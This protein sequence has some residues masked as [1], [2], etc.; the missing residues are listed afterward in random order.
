M[1]LG[2]SDLSQEDL[3]SRLKLANADLAYDVT[4][5]KVKVIH[6]KHEHEWTYSA[7][8]DGYSIAATCKGQY[9]ASHC[10]Y[11]RDGETISLMSSKR[12]DLSFTYN[13]KQRDAVLATTKPSQKDNAVAQGKV[14]IVC[15]RF[16]RCADENDT[17]GIEMEGSQPCDAGTYRVVATVAIE[18][19]SDVTLERVFKINP[20][21]LAEKD[22]NRKDLCK[23]EVIG[24]DKLKDS[25][26]FSNGD[27]LND[28]PSYKWT[29]EEITPRIKVTYKLGDEW[30]E[31]KEGVDFERLA[32]GESVSEKDPGAYRSQLWGLGN[33][34]SYESIYSCKFFYWSIYGTQFE[35][36]Q[37][38]ALTAPMMARLTRRR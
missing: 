29:G 3:A 18:G 24:Y 26:R 11:S 22:S 17:V 5:D 37:A 15:A 16:Y 31:L 28:V 13:G 7:N 38:K 33:F 21:S 20:A 30:I 19:Q 27:V 25:V 23:I 34:A 10:V 12:G 9:E 2:T 35:N 6:R 36:V 8:K 1:N 14:K 32:W 4:G